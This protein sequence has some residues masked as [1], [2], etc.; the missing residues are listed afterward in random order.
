MFIKINNTALKWLGYDR[1][2]MIGKFNFGD[3]LTAESREAFKTNFRIF[4]ERG[5]VDNLEYDMVRKDGTMLPVLLSATAV[6]DANG[7][8]VMTRSTTIDHTVRRNH[9]KEILKLNAI[10]QE[11]SISLE[12]A[13]KELE[14]FTYS[15]SHDLRAPLRAING[16]SQILLDEYGSRLDDASKTLL[17]KV[18]NNASRMRQLIDDLLRLSRTS[19]QELKYALI[20]MPALF[21][22]MLEEIRQ[23]FPNRTIQAKIDNMPS[24]YADLALLKQVLSNLLS[25]AVKFS[26]RAEITEIETGCSSVDSEHVF[27]IKDNGAGFDMKFATDLFGVFKRLENAGE[28]EGTGVGL[29]LVKRIIDKHGGRVWANSEPSKGATFYF[30]LP[31]SK[32]S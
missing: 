12:Y 1:D 29:A 11:H 21:N 31:V 24:V 23:Q 25:N 14:A 27:Y 32:I 30:S 22:S 8:I 19:R 20:D 2:E 5:Y 4:K 7:N 17:E 3:L 26:S 13:N 6:K 9:E 15:V 10:L 18:V 28:Y 16:F